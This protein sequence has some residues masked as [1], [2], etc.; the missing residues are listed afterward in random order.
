M[1]HMVLKETQI[2]LEESKC[3]IV[4]C[5]CFLVILVRVWSHFQ[6][7]PSEIITE[8]SENKVARGKRKKKSP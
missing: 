8:A 2:V 4:F 3:E 6:T 5:G 1:T 7:V